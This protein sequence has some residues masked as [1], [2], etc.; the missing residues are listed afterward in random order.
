MVIRELEGL[1]TN[2]DMTSPVKKHVITLDITVDNV[3]AVQMGQSLAG[4]LAVPIV[5][6]KFMVMV[7]VYS[8]TSAQIV[9]I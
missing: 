8:R 7:D 9:A 3:L 6:I 2:L 1:L 4:L 5:S